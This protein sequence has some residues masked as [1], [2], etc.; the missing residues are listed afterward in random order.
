M[1][2][3]LEKTYDG[4]EGK[5]IILVILGIIVVSLIVFIALHCI[6]FKKPPRNLDSEK[7]ASQ[8]I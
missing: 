5:W 6:E 3:F 4:V 1:L 2:S 8:K 7:N